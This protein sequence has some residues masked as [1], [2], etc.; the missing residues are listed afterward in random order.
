[1]K[2]LLVN[3]SDLKGGAAIAAYRLM[4]TLN[5]NGAS[6]KMMVA[7]KLSDDKNVIQVGDTFQRNWSFY[8]ERVN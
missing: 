4:K 1:M 6:A 3:T 8:S 7:E 5:A 2:I